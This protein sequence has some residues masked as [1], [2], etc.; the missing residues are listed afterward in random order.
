M[1]ISFLKLL[2]SNPGVK[3]R[4]DEVYKQYQSRNGNYGKGDN[5]HNQVVVSRCDGGE[6][7]MTNSRIGKD[8]FRD[9]GPAENL[10]KGQGQVCNLRQHGVADHIPE[11]DLALGD[12][13]QLSV[14]HEVF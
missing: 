11:H 8:N 10:S 14:L 6:Q 3:Q 12:S 4:I 9:Q 13:A 2:E 7:E 1:A 5:T